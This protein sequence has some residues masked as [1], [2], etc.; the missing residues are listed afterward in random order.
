VLAL[1]GFAA[2]FGCGSSRPA[3]T[4][5]S[6]LA[7]APKVAVV[8]PPCSKEE[9]EACDLGSSQ[10]CLL[11]AGVYM[12]GQPLPKNSRRAAQLNDKACEGGAPV[13]CL[14]LGLMYDRGI[15]TKRDAKRAS[16]LFKKG[17]GA[18][19]KAD[20]DAMKAAAWPK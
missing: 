1:L 7:E 8:P 6:E 3:P 20:C 16:E 12:T 5:P 13:G 17:C 11:I 2:V 4:A 9:P 19:S 15:G 18:R 10:A 14:R